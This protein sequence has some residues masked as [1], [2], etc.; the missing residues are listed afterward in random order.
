MKTRIQVLVKK[1]GT[2]QTRSEDQ[3]SGKR[4]RERGRDRRE[5]CAQVPLKCNI[6]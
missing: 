2:D 4:G 6:K 5:E 3:C 1:N